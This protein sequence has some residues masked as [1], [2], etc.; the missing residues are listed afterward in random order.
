MVLK[1]EKMNEL[2]DNFNKEIENIR[3]YQIEVAGLKNTIAELKI[4]STEFNSRVDETNNGSV[5]REKWK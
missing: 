1:L 3:N 2:S 4:T 5:S